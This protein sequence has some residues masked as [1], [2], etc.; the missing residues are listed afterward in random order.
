MGEVAV[1]FPVRP[2]VVGAMGRPSALLVEMIVEMDD[3]QVHHVPDRGFE[4]VEIEI[5]AGAYKL[6]VHGLAEVVF[7]VGHEIHA[8]PG[9]AHQLLVVAVVHHP[10]AP[11]VSQELLEFQAELLLDTP[12]ISPADSGTRA[13]SLRN[14]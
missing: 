2:D 7:A 3:V 13:R 10:Q 9:G 5:V 14:R 8:P 1:G 6:E 11:V 4:G 12:G